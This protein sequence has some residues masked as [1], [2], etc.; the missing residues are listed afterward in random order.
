MK[1][2]TTG[3]TWIL[4]QLHPAEWHF[5]CELPE[6]IAGRGFDEKAKR[7]LLPGPFREASEDGEGEEE[8]LEDWEEFVKPDIEAAFKESRDV[9]EK[10]LERGEISDPPE[11]EMPEDIDP[12]QAA[13]LDEFLGLTWRRIEISLDHVEA[14]Y[15]TLNQAR[16]LM[17]E[18]HRIADDEARFSVRE[19]NDGLDP[20]RAMLL[21]HYE[22][23]S[24]LQSI[25][26]DQLMEP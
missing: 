16:I 1:F 13:I 15:S 26:I 3:K 25:M 7:R 14:W 4:D 17:N 18:A 24:V 12:E 6:L 2:Y 8:F 22:F 19:G 21:T 5:I 20:D 10:D 23:Y 11:L 9:V